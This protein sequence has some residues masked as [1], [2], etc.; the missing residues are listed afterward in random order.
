ML[1]TLLT[2]LIFE[3]GSHFYTQAGLDVT[4]LFVLR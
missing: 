4:P 1:P 3:T 2:V